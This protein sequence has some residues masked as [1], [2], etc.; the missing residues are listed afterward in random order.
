MLPDDKS[1]T[2]DPEVEILVIK[3][4]GGDFTDHIKC[5]NSAEHIFKSLKHA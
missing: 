4:I 2:R 1:R 3:T 5:E